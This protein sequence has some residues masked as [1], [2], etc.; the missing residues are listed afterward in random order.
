MINEATA[1]A[2]ALKGRRSGAG[3]VCRC[4]AH[5][6][7]RPSL[8]VT[9][10]ASGRLLLKCHAG[11][12]GRN[13]LAE[14]QRRGIVTGKGSGSSPLTACERKQLHQEDAENR[15]RR[16]AAARKIWSECTDIHGS[17]AETYLRERGLRPPF[18]GTLRYH[19]AAH[20]GATGQKLPAMVAAVTLWPSRQ[21]VAVHRTFLTHDGSRKAP[22]TPDKMMLGPV[23]GAAVRLGPAAEEMAVSE[24]IENGLSVQQAAGVATW[25]ALSAG[26]VETLVLPALPLAADITICADPDPRGLEAAEKAAGRWDR[27]GRRV[28]IAHPP[29]VGVDFNDVLIGPEAEGGEYGLYP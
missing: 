28:K 24:G 17:P 9:T 2:A 4:P 15:Q 22:V 16:T 6:D 27:E 10:G 25:S 21:V 12:D 23:K 7:R 14:L 26:G 3:W 1:V 20:H 13:V 29:V 18:P 5:E 11:C 19:P 8:S